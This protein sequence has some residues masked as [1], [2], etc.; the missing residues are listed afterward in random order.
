MK[1]TTAPGKQC[2]CQKGFFGPGCKN[3]N[4]KSLSETRVQ[5]GLYTKKELSE[6]VTLLWRILKED[7]EIEVVIKSKGTSWVGL[8]WRPKGLSSSCKKFPVLADQDPQARSLNLQPEP[9]PESEP[10][11]EPAHH[12]Y[13]DIEAE[14]EAEAESEPSAA[15]QIQEPREKRMSTRTDVGISFVM[16]SISSSNRNKREAQYTRRFPRAFA[17]PLN[18]EESTAEPGIVETP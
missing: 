10:E 1:A 8:G 14:A 9:E 4:P 7:Q 15:A 3:K 12:K 18:D 6:K 16:S 17:V 13:D 11:S 5:D 2:F